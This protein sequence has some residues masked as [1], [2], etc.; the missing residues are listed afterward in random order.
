MYRRVLASVLVF[1]MAAGAI[2]V[3]AAGVSALGVVTQASRANLAGANVSAGSTLYDGDSLTTA[4]DGL[5]R[6][7]AG[8]A[9]LYLP[10]ESGVKLHSISGGMLA[11]LTGG[12][13]VFSSAKAAAM[14]IEIAQ[15]HVRPV[16]DQPTVAQISVVGPK[17]IDIRA[18]RGALQFSYDGETQLIPEGS[19]YRFVLDPPEEE[20]LSE[21][22]PAFP[23]QRGRRPPPTRRNKAFLY[24]IIGATA[25]LTYVA[26]D[27]ALESPSKP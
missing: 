11:Q 6:I 19:A 16:A 24:F 21:P 7:H 12:R 1:V 9:Q 27:E 3:H 18:Q 17:I 10:G 20:T 15:A 8:A 5:L 2:P 22:T 26:I 13:L 25:V 14:D 23:G 4:S